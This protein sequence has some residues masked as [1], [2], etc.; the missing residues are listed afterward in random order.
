ME[1]RAWR[2]ITT[3][4][5]L[6]VLLVVLPLLSACASTTSNQSGAELTAPEEETVVMAASTCVACHSNEDL[7]KETVAPVEEKTEEPSGE[8]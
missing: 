6:A 1:P 5:G 8:G 3:I 2:K 4:I 7:L